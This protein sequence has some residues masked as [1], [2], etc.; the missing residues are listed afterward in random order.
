LRNFILTEENY[1]KWRQVIDS[2]RYVSLQK[3]YKK[4]FVVRLN[5]EW[6]SYLLQQL[7]EQPLRTNT[8]CFLR[9][10]RKRNCVPFESIWVHPIRLKTG[11][12]FL[13]C[14]FYV[15]CFRV[16][17]IFTFLCCVFVFVCLRSVSCSKCCLCLWIVYSWLYIRVSLVNTDSGDY[18]CKLNNENKL[19]TKPSKTG[20]VVIIKYELLTCREHLG[21][22]PIC[23]GV[24][25]ADL[26]IFLCCVS[27]IVCICLVSFVPNVFSVSWF[28]ILDYL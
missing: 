4:Y 7:I 13:I 3:Q 20:F 24:R 9:S 5:S 2:W 1:C 21:S 11:T 17:H 26:F 8:A 28:S 18:V 14:L 15:L 19:K 22:P 10:K 12:V 23:G 27:Y 6:S 25:V 16:A